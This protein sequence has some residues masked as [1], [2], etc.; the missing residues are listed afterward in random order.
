MPLDKEHD[1]YERRTLMTVRRDYTGDLDTMLYPLATTADDEVYYDKET[2]YAS[3]GRD[4]QQ[5]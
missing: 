3:S 1:S 5:F 4:Q 2:T